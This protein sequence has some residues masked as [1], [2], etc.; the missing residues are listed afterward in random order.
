M[1]TKPIPSIAWDPENKK[2]ITGN[3]P[4]RVW[5]IEEIN[6]NFNETYTI[7]GQNMLQLVKLSIIMQNVCLN[8]QG[9]G[10]SA[11][12]IGIP[13]RFFVV[14]QPKG[15]SDFLTLADAFYTPF[16]DQTFDSIEGC[17]SILE[18]NHLVFYKIPRAKK[19]DVVGKLM[20]MDKDIVYFDTVSLQV[21]NFYSSLFAHEIDHQNFI[22]ISKIG[23]RHTE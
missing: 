18:E 16:D 13:L 5:G 19:I 9:V 17:L 6:K 21:E 23:T 4:N 14:L 2:L 22:D 12:Q 3:S 11:I 7:E 8:M 20:K 10:L 15:K 1:A